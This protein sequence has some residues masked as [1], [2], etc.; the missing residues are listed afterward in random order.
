MF[1]TNVISNRMHDLAKPYITIYITDV[2]SLRPDTKWM[3]NH[4][5]NIFYYLQYCNNK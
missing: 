1:V 3:D 4:N 2:H 5:H